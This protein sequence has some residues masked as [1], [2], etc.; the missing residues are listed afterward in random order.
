MATDTGGEVGDGPGNPPVPV[1]S[2]CGQQHFP[3]APCPGAPKRGGDG[4]GDETEG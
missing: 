1:C 2:V 4:D 3:S